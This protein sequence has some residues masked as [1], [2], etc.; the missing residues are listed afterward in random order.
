[1]RYPAMSTTIVQPVVVVEVEADS[2]FS[3]FLIPGFPTLFHAQDRRFKY[4]KCGLS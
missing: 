3:H 2:P 4:L 1:M